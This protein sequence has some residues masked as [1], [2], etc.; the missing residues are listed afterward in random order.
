VDHKTYEGGK[1]ET[2]STETNI[3]VVSAKIKM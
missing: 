1:P 3:E 2:N